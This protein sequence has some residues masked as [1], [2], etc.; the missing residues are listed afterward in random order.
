[1]NHFQVENSAEAERGYLVGLALK[2]GRPLLSIED[3][4]AELA[5][6]AETA[7]IRVVGQTQQHIRQ[8]NPKTFIGSGKLREILDDVAHCEA[9]RRHL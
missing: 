1:M 9:G 8:I 7:G 6:L 2:Q 5:L 4:L 3:S